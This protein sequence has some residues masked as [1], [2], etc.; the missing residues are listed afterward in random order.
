LI[1]RATPEISAADAPSEKCVASEELGIGQSEIDADVGEIEAD[2]A[3]SVPRRVNYFCFEKAPAERVAFFEQMIDLGDFRWR[4]A[5]ERG[6]HIHALVER[7]IFA[8][9]EDGRSGEMVELG[10]AADVV[11]VRV[12]ADDSFYG[13]AMA[14]K[15]FED[16]SDFI[17]R[18]D[19]DGFTR[20]R[21]ADDS[22]I[23]LQHTD[24][25]GDLDD[26]VGIGVEKLW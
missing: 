2:A 20:N 18:I 16:A 11:D 23:A 17:T 8:V 9:H 25:D 3:W 4:D 12:S 15:K 21:I 10:Q 22:A 6:L 7:E 13:E 26:A 24:R 5:E 1:H 14:A 19:D